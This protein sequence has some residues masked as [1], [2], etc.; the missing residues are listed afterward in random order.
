MTGDRPEE[1]ST[2]PTPQSSLKVK[3]VR[4]SAGLLAITGASILI[5]IASVEYSVARTGLATLETQIR[6][7]LT[8]R[9][10][11]LT[12]SQAVAFRALVEDTA[13]TEM[14]RTIA[15]SVEGKDIVYGVFTDQNG[16]PWSYCSPYSPCL[17]EDP[18]KEF[19]VTQSAQVTRDLKLPAPL[20]QI[21]NKQVRE[22]FLFGEQVLEFAEPIVLDDELAG[23][24]R[25]G[26]S[27]SGL[28]S[29]LQE[30]RNERQSVLI[31]ALLTVGLVVGLTLLVGIA[32]AMRTARKITRPISE[33]T[34]AAQNLAR[35]TRGARVAINSGDELE[36][37][38]RAFNRMVSDLD[39]SYSVLEAKNAELSREAEE[40][41][42]A[43]AERS[44]LQNHLVQS[45]K[46]EAFGQL[47]GGVAH[48]FN[49]ILAVI[50]GS[51]ELTAAIMDDDGGDPEIRKLVDQISQAADR[52]ANLTRQLLMF[53]RRESDNPQIVDANDVLTGFDKLIRRILEE[54]VTISVNTSPDLPK[55][56]IDPGR[57][58]Q[59]LMNLCVNARDAMPEGGQLNL[60][61]HSVLIAAPRRLTSGMAGAG[62]YIVIEAAD[63]GSGMPEEVVG[64]VFEPFFTTK[65]AGH[66]TGLGLATVHGIVRAASGFIDLHSQLG[67]GTTFSIYLPAYEGVLQ[68]DEDGASLPPPSGR[69]QRIILCE[70]ENPV[71]EMTQAILERGGYKV[72]STEF[73]EEALRMLEAHQFDLLVTDVVMPR[74][75]GG[76][77][78]DSARKIWPLLPVLFVSGYTGG[79]V[80]A[81]GISAESCELLRKPFTVRDILERVDKLL[82]ASRAAKGDAS[83]SCRKS[84]PGFTRPN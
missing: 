30:A 20:P 48:D 14:R 50:V 51:A 81:H 80:N 53:A 18:Q 60:S 72:S 62:R 45:Q 73:A 47:A 77:L 43:Q 16:Q 57:L 83:T 63:N 44:E 22:V 58:E 52:G 64:R 40:R 82:T 21:S 55:V 67:V 4:A 70:D 61:T 42:Q 78:A 26:L 34:K 68:A 38:G 76:Q 11:S 25:Y 71:R 5:V 9:G 28:E 69:G 3:L 10:E 29:A 65:M 75:N 7:T 41:R 79:I 8:S 32:F 24:L 74:M 59:V 17:P 12:A 56:Q 84:V 35:G 37:L 33:L 2:K 1:Y 39:S 19:G 46:M 27:T 6:E 49:N 15:Q 54:T 31:R 66:G 36:L 23:T 13:V